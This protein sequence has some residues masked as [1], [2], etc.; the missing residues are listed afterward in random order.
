MSISLLVG[1][2]NLFKN[3]LQYCQLSDGLLA[4]LV[5]TNVARR[6]PGQLLTS[7]GG[8]DWTTSASCRAEALPFPGRSSLADRPL[9]SGILFA[10][11]RGIR[12]NESPIDTGCRSGISCWRDLHDGQQAGIP[13]R[14]HGIPLVKLCSAAR[15]G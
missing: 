3:E 9:L 12:W 14:L 4:S 15:I 1:S 13:D 7:I 8:I 10:L 5:A 11:S 2:W 6:W